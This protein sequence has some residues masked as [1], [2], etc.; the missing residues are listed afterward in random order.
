MPLKQ[1]TIPRIELVAAAVG[2]KVVQYVQRQLHLDSTKITAWSDSKCVLYWL[3]HPKPESLPRFIHNRIKTIRET[4]I[5]FRYVPTHD[6]PADI[7][8]RG[9]TP[10]QLQENQLWWK[11]PQW[12][13]QSEETWPT[14]IPITEDPTTESSPANSGTEDNAALTITKA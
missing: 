13:A 5:Q 2:V 1:L 10:S 3:T 9:C 7:G 14:N 12:P 8:S 6:N 11:G 4:G